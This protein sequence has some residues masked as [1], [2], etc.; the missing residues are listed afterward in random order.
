M[1]IGPLLGSGAKGQHGRHLGFWREFSPKLP[2]GPALKQLKN[3]R[4][5]LNRSDTEL[6]I[7]TNTGMAVTGGRREASNMIRA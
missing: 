1:K 3:G 5:G 2:S 6:L 7:W 4:D